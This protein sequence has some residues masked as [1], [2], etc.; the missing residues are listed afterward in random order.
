MRQVCVIGNMPQTHIFG[1]NII[2]SWILKTNYLKTDYCLCIDI[3]KL[4]INGSI[5]NIC[6]K[7]TFQSYLVSKNQI[8]V[9]MKSDDCVM[10]Y[11]LCLAVFT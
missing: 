6:P 5:V 8:E 3:I 4:R 10:V 9:Y 7:S 2:I 1:S 11:I